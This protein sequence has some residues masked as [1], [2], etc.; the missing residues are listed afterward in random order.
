VEANEIKDRRIIRKISKT[1]TRFLV[2]IK[3]I[4]KHLVVTAE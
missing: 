4:D 2:K 3:E 1:K